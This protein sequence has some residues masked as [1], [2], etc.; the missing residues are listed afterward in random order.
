VF[1][2]DET[3][4]GV[5]MAVRELDAVCEGSATA[6]MLAAAVNE[7]AEEEVPLMYPEREEVALLMAVREARALKVAARDVEGEPELDRETMIE[8]VA[9]PLMV[10]DFE[11]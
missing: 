8:L 11:K 2:L 3:A 7:K 4:E 6:V 5:R 1:T 9:L 10:E